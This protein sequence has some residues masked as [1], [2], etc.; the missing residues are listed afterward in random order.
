M[1]NKVELTLI[2]QDSNGPASYLRQY[3]VCSEGLDCPDD[4]SSMVLHRTSELAHFQAFALETGL[5]VLSR[6]VETETCAF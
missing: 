4:T 6:I 2:Q 5:A 3:C 1:R